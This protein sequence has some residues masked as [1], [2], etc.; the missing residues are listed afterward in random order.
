MIKAV[1]RNKAK[2]WRKTYGK[3]FIRR[4]AQCKAHIIIESACN[5]SKSL[6]EH[7]F[8]SLA[9]AVHEA[10]LGLNN[11]TKAMKDKEHA[12]NKGFAK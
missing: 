10:S 11:L 8:L 5:V 3:V 4:R 2:V 12:M 9:C 6:S 1:K 7:P